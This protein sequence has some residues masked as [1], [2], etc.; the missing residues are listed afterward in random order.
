M[1]L[2]PMM[3]QSNREVLLRIL[4][5]FLLVLLMGALHGCNT[6]RGVRDDVTRAFYNE[7][8]PE[9]PF[10]Y[11]RKI[12]F[13][14]Q[15]NCRAKTMPKID[16]AHVFATE[17]KLFDGF[18]V[19]PQVMVEEA[20][21]K[22]GIVLDGPEGFRELGQYLGVDAVALVMIHD[23]RQQPT[24]LVKMEL[25]LYPVKFSNY[26]IND[27]Q[28]MTTFGVD[29]RMGISNRNAP[30]IGFCKEYDYD[31]RRVVARLAGY[32]DAHGSE[33]TGM[34][35]ER[36]AYVPEYYVKF[37]ANEMIRE[38]IFLEKS[39]QEKEAKYQAIVQ[40]AMERGEYVQAPA[41]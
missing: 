2:Q 23:Y 31:D 33:S 13:L 22:S 6:W 32:A 40:H 5:L 14:P 36:F 17:L 24:P 1:T 19:V 29:A 28:T 41:G 38:M 8:N 16:F 21:L 20:R 7:E 30:V 27:V 3:Q 11:V 26:G 25:Q 12:A 18:D 35:R 9:N 4:A 34:G 39:R 37:C 10:K 15:L